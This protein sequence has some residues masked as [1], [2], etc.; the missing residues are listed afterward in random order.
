MRK[1][2]L[3]D[4]QATLA[5][6]VDEAARSNPS[7]ITR[8]GKPQAVVL[9]FVDWER[10]SRVPSFGWRRRLNRETCRSAT[11]RRCATPACQWR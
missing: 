6:L 9:G 2:Q 8:H 7:L 3:K 4:A 10:L 5:A 11:V 1:I